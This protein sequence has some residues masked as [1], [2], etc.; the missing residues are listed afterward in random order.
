MLS[1][2]QNYFI[3]K[4]KQKENTSFAINFVIYAN[5]DML[6]VCI[7]SKITFV[8]PLHL[9][10]MQLFGLYEFKYNQKHFMLLMSYANIGM[11]RACIQNKNTS[12]LLNL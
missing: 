3:Y 7:Q 5:I 9:W 1:F 8:M 11:L 12:W 10:Y 4:T 6:R 2:V